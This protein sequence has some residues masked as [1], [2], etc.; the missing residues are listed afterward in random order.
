MKEI[1]FMDSL[2]QKAAE[3]GDPAG[4]C[5]M[6]LSLSLSDSRADKLK[7]AK[8]MKQ[9]AD[10]GCGRA[11]TYYDW[12]V[13]DRNGLGDPS[14]DIDK[15]RFWAVTQNRCQKLF[16][17]AA[18]YHR[19]N[20][21][22]KDIHEAIRLY[23]LAADCGHSESCFA[24]SEIYRTGE[25]GIAPNP[26]RSILYAR[27]NYEK[28]LEGEQ[29]GDERDFLGLLSFAEFQSS[30][31]DTIPKDEEQSKKLLLIAHRKCFAFQQH[32]Y[33]QRLKDGEG[34]RKDEQKSDAYFALAA[35]HGYPA[36]FMSVPLKRDSN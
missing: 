34:V 5:E 32:R 35:S 22:D 25:D 31:F 9:A 1:E 12:L 6:A 11:G 3:L 17:F 36:L 14:V 15:Y 20:G 30:G 26:A 13:A 33:A 28:G 10:R 18:A 24:L 27:R 19:G 16:Y 4:I 21:V 8:L 29:Q 7:G 23:E 2:Y